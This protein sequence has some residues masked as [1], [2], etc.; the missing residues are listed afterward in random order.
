MI[1]THEKTS[2]G[3]QRS[4]KR[5]GS[6]KLSPSNAKI[7]STPQYTL[8]FLFLNLVKVEIFMQEDCESRV[9]KNW[10]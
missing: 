2:Q 10:S 9:K 5:E 1:I 6:S 8:S 3:L 4:R 7:I